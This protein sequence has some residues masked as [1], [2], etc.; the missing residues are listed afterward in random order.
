MRWYPR[1]VFSS[2]TCIGMTA[3]ISLYRRC[4]NIFYKDVI[5]DARTKLLCRDTSRDDCRTLFLAYT[6][7]DGRDVSRD[8]CRLQFLRDAS[9]ADCRNLFCRDANRNSRRIPFS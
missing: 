5:G 1:F 7:R 8:D 3:E 2:F 4:R 6:S 9:R